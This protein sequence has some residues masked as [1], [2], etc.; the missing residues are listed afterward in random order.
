MSEYDTIIAGASF[1]GLIAADNIEGTVLLIDRKEIGTHQTSSC[2]TFTSVLEGL[3]CRNTILQEFDTLILHIPEERKVELIEPISTFDYEKFCKTVAH[4]IKAKILKTSVKGVTGQTVIT[5]SETFDSQCILD[6]TGWKAVLASSI[7][8]DYVD[9]QKLSFGIESEV[10]HTDDSLH[11]FVDP[12]IIKQGAAWIFP[13]GNKSRIGLAS[14]AGR[15]NILPELS[16]FLKTMSLDVEYIHGGYFPSCLREPAVGNIFMVGDSAGMAAPTTGEGIRYAVRYSREC[17]RIV[18]S[19]IDGDKTLEHGLRE[20]RDVVYRS[21][22][23]YDMLMN[24]QNRLLS[25]ILPET[26]K[27]AAYSRV[28]SGLFQKMYLGI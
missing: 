24:M 23:G 16:E 17:A 7:K 2:A 22:W 4:R 1:A 15:T 19:I 12:K 20:Y 10:E 3:G 18:Q 8:N 21:K 9:R 11:F 5:G 28:F 25:N 13:I 14:Y 26:I 6:C 27:K